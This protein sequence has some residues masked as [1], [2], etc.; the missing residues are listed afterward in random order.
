M[1]G[2]LIFV[3]GIGVRTDGMNSTLKQVRD[4]LARAGCPLDDTGANGIKVVGADW[5]GKFGTSGERASLVL[6][7]AAGRG[8]GVAEEPIPDEI[9]V[10]ALLL[11]EPLA[12]LQLAAP[13]VAPKVGGAFG[14]GETP[15]PRPEAARLRG[16][17]KTL[18]TRVPDEKRPPDIPAARLAE[19]A[20]AVEAAPAF[21]A[22][23][24]AARDLTSGEFFALTARAVVAEVLALSPDGERPGIAFDASARDAF[25]NAVGET[26]MAADGRGL[27]PG[28]VKKGMVAAAKQIGT[29]IARAHRDDLTQV[30]LP[31]VGD[32]LMYQRHSKEVLDFLAGKIAGLPTPV[33]VFAHSLGGV[34][35]VDLLSRADHPHVDLLVTLGSQAPLFFLVN[36]LGD[37]TDEA[38]P[39]PFTPWANLYDRNDFLSYVAEGVFP[40]PPGARGEPTIKD[41]PIDSGVPFPDSHGGYFVNDRTYEIVRNRWPADG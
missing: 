1:R 12:E 38:D 30:A 6:P 4:G 33:V 15:A 40:P 25:V 31:R 7:S 13:R 32:V 5:G 21:G 3:H 2:S 28:F 14:L 17:L 35:A 10:W 34:M 8:V 29:P 41:Y 16:A 37:L 19:A 23:L 36:A 39:E 20:I 26:L 24:D 9:A 27:M 18:A 22:A 11:A